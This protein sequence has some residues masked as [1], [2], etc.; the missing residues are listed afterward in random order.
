MKL[1]NWKLVEDQDPYQPPELRRKRLSGEVF[2]HPRHDD[3]SRVV[4]S[5]VESIDGRVVRTFSGS[6]YTLGDP[7]PDYV[8]W[9]QENGHYTELFDE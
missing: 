7:D 2:G 9:C 3:G 1:N 6:E 4:T 8:E 5:E